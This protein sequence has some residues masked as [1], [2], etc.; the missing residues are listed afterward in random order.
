[1]LAGSNATPADDEEEIRRREKEF[2]QKLSEPSKVVDGL[3][4]LLSKHK[5]ELLDNS[6]T[7]ENGDNALRVDMGRSDLDHG[8]DNEI[9]DDEDVPPRRH[10]KKSRRA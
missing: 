3:K 5:G 10:G 7:A 9:C 1:M 2:F 6:V 8:D 4:Y